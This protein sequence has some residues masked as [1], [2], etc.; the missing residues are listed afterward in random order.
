MSPNSTRPSN[1]RIHEH[2][3]I[4]FSAY[5]RAN[6]Y[7]SDPTRHL[8]NIKANPPAHCYQMYRSR[9][10]HE[11]LI[12]IVH[13]MTSLVYFVDVGLH[14]EFPS[15]ALKA[16]AATYLYSSTHYIMLTSHI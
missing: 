16:E 15:G 9:F 14:Y 5:V 8:T 13:V 11:A 4:F 2:H 6:E 3:L 1:L 7:F 10:A 12:H